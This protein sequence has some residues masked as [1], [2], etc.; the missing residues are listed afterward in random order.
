MIL[1]YQIAKGL[2]SSVRH[3]QL[4]Q[5]HV[6]GSSFETSG[7]DRSA[8]IKVFCPDML[9]LCLRAYLLKEAFNRSVN[10]VGLTERAGS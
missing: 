1:V 2:Q 9:K 10:M 8:R 5:Y 6:S 4:P 3:H 7:P